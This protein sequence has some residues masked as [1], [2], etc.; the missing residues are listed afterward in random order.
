MGRE[1][2]KH[3][4]TCSCVFTQSCKNLYFFSELKI[5]LAFEEDR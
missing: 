4:N 1:L 3:G 5:F 2:L